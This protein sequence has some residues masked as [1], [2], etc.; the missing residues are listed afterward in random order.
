MKTPQNTGDNFVEV[1]VEIGSAGISY[2]PNIVLSPEQILAKISQADDL[3]N[4][5]R[6][7]TAFDAIVKAIFAFVGIA[8]MVFCVSLMVVFVGFNLGIGNEFGESIITFLQIS[9][10]LMP[11]AGSGLVIRRHMIENKKITRK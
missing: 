7:K 4:Q 1:S 8:G 9:L 3:L 11:F 6:P 10:V 5:V 2:N